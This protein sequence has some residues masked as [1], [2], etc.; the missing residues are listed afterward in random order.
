MQQVVFWAGVNHDFHFG[1]GTACTV[2]AALTQFLYIAEIL[3]VGVLFFYTDR[4]VVGAISVSDIRKRYLVR[5]CVAPRQAGLRP[6][7]SASV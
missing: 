1:N 6:P 4:L 7:S 5:S 3:E 2:Q